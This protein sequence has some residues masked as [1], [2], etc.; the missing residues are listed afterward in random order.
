MDRSARGPAFVRAAGNTV[1]TS[2]QIPSLNN[3]LTYS[4]PASTTR[5][6]HTRVILSVLQPRQQSQKQTQYN[7]CRRIYLPAATIPFG[8]LL[9]GMP[10]RIENASDVFK[11]SAGLQRRHVSRRHLRTVAECYAHHHET[12]SQSKTPWQIRELHSAT[13][14]KRRSTCLPKR[15]PPSEN[16][17]S[18]QK[19]PPP[20]GLFNSGK[21]SIHLLALL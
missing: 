16:H 6:E 11:A 3:A 15:A 7:N 4:C 9:A 17:T 19:V 8:S 1:Y 13:S 12:T 14:R 5:I 18:A 10:R 2:T 21:M 20:F